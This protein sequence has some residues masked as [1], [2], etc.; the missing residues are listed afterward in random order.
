ML[1]VKH[2]QFSITKPSNQTSKVVHSK[3]WA[4]GYLAFVLFYG[5]KQESRSAWDIGTYNGV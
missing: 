5:Q 2:E 4:S 1:D 3:A